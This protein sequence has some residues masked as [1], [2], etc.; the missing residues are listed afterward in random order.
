MLSRGTVRTVRIDTHRVIDY[1]VVNRAARRSMAKKSLIKW[2]NLGTSSV[3]VTC[4][5]GP[6]TTGCLQSEL[7]SGDRI[8]AAKRIARK[9]VR[10][11]GHAVHLDIVQEQQF[12][13]EEEGS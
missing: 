8:L 1:L 9:H 10:E 7:Y 4:I 2:M 6:E 3:L 13:P 12:W 11:T 5:G